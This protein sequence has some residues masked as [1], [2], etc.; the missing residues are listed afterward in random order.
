ML[1]ISYDHLNALVAHAR[2]EDPNECCG[3]L[4]GSDDTV[5]AAYRI[6][7]IA[8]SPYRYLMDSQ[9]F[10]D[11]DRK[12]LLNIKGLGEKTLTKITNLII[13]NKFYKALEAKYHA[14]IA[15]GKAVL[16]TY[17]NDSVGIGDHSE[18]LKECD[19]WMCVISH[20]EENIL[21]LRKHFE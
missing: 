19:K 21:N 14:Q 7:N 5:M 8:K 18:L 9:E 13:E 10:L 4:V 3:I 20:A 15:E 6:S 16:L 11:A 2:S 12:T 17:F 1:H